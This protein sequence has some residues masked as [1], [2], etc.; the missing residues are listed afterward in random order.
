[1]S[2]G[3]V[4]GSALLSRAR[5]SG[6]CRQN[7]GC[8]ILELHASLSCYLGGK[9]LL[10]KRAVF[11]RQKL[12]KKKKKAMKNMQNAFPDASEESRHAL[13]PPA[14]GVGGAA[15]TCGWPTCSEQGEQW[16]PLTACD[17]KFF[18]AQAAHTKTLKLQQKK[19]QSKSSSP[20]HYNKSLVPAS[21][22]AFITIVQADGKKKKNSRHSEINLR[23][24]SPRL[25][26]EIKPVEHTGR[27][28]CSHR[29][30]LEY[31]P[32]DLPGMHMEVPSAFPM[33]RKK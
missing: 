5:L 30:S 29:P 7:Q 9:F 23:L 11:L 26:L 20:S 32:A 22:F 19:G 4:P 3:R 24:I 8:E 16:L 13:S 12:K 18:P 15:G 17:Y 28:V 25:S 21:A 33:E 1:M 27:G 31:C 14:L 2:L 10:W 6:K